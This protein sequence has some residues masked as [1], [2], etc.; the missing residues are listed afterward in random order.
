MLALCKWEQL[1]NTP[2]SLLSLI[3]LIPFRHGSNLHHRTGAAQL[4]PPSK[5]RSS[6][7]NQVGFGS[8]HTVT[9]TCTSFTLQPG[10]VVEINQIKHRKYLHSYLPLFSR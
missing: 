8:I 2:H 1:M 3:D 9:T 7:A 10:S 6:T 4:H 5:I